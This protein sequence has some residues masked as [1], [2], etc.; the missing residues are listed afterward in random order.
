MNTTLNIYTKRRIQFR[1]V[2]TET[3][4]LV[5]AVLVEQHG[6]QTTYSEPRLIKVIAKKTQALPGSVGTL[7]LSGSI[8]KNSNPRGA[9][10][11]P[12][13]SLFS[14]QTENILN[15]YGARPPCVQ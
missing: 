14:T 13:V 1:T 4:L 3:S 6:N 2:E 9:I 10:L 7:A 8:A 15:W 11:S 12:F 5:F